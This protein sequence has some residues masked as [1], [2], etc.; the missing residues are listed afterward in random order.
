[1]AQIHG[2]YLNGEMMGHVL[3]RGEIDD[4]VELYR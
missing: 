3:S 2:A 1:M 4:K